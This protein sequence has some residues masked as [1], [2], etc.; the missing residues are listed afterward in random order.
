MKSQNL[1]EDEVDVNRKLQCTNLNFFSHLVNSLYNYDCITSISAMRKFEDRQIKIDIIANDNQTWVKI[2]ARNSES[3]K[4]EVLGRCEYGSKD[5]LAVAEE[6]L[7]VASSQLNFFRPPNVVF[8]FLNRIDEK[9]ENALEEKGIILGRK[10]RES[11]KTYEKI[12]SKLN[13]DI[14]TMLAYV[15]ELSN[16]GTNFQFNEKL[17]EEQAATER[18][19]PI[20]PILDE[21]FKD[22][23][24]ICCETAVR[25]FDEIIELLAGPNE[26]VRAEELKSR[27]KILPDVTSPEKIINLDITAQIK[28]RSRKIFAFGIHHKA[29]TISS[30]SGFRRVA[31][32]KQVDIPMVTHS[33]RALTEL[34]QI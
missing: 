9:L 31:K 29:I 15:S 27:M 34:K 2:I 21:I 18:K 11:T 12:S 20:K 5:I 1:A 19:A 22:K 4:D 17:L 26:K 30:N 7:D 3:I 8:D 25:S 6:F 10:F 14:T 13:I 28:E 16:G 32:M 24:L 23:E 33:A